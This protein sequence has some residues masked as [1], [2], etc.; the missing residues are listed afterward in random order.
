[1]LEAILGDKSEHEKKV[2]ELVEELGAYEHVRDLA[3]HPGWPTFIQA[4]E[5]QAKQYRELCADLLDNILIRRNASDEAA[6]TDARVH[7]LAREEAMQI[8][9][10]IRENAKTAKTLLDAM[11]A[12]GQDSPQIG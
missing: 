3:L 7:L 6:F 2:S 12:N 9:L 5:K 8:Y 10:K 11:P 1:M 4:L